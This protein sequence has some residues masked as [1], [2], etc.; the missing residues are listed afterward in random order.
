LLRT[1]AAGPG[2]ESD[3]THKGIAMPDLRFTIGAVLATALLT[4][5]AFGVTATLRL[6]QHAKLGPLDLARSLAYSDSSDWN[7]FADPTATRRFEELMRPVEGV[8]MPITEV[9]TTSGPVPAAPSALPEAGAQDL[10]GVAPLVSLAVADARAPA[11]VAEAPPAPAAIDQPPA[12]PL[13]ILPPELQPRPSQ[14]LPAIAPQETVLPT[15]FVQIPEVVASVR[16]VA[17]TM[18]AQAPDS[19]PSTRDAVARAPTPSPELVTSTAPQVASHNELPL[20]PAA[21][22]SIEIMPQPATASAS[23]ANPASAGAASSLERPPVATDT[24]APEPTTNLTAVTTPASPA[25]H[26]QPTIVALTMDPGNAAPTEPTRAAPTPVEAP[27]TDLTSTEPALA[28]QPALPTPVVTPL[29]AAEGERIASLPTE[30]RDVTALRDIRVTAAP[31]PPLPRAAPRR[32]LAALQV[33]IPIKRHSVVHHARVVR[34][35]RIAPAQ[36][37]P[38]PFGPA[39]FTATTAQPVDLFAPTLTK[40]ARK[41]SG[42]LSTRAPYGPNSSGTD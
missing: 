7:Q 18:P 29:K 4:V 28:E 37:A 8:T 5:T 40:P 2:V 34:F 30:R 1:A 14:V 16:P 32:R 39:S 26:E 33:H 11:A 38:A 41:R 13:A 21:T 17:T 35:V 15:A 19:E 42:A 24:T 9:T 3:S 22:A 31:L 12:E 10:T 23:E 6:A 27:P 25:V 20:E 36:P